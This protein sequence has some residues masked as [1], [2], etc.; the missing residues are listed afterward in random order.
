MKYLYDLHQLSPL[1]LVKQLFLQSLHVHVHAHAHVHGGVHIMVIIMKFIVCAGTDYT[2]TGLTW[3]TCPWTNKPQTKE[4]GGGH[5]QEGYSPPDCY[6]TKRKRRMQEL[7]LIF[8]LWCLMQD[9]AYIANKLCL[10]TSKLSK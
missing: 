1:Y 8:S 9:I 10:A 7:I 4:G 6:L 5:V 2:Q 3:S